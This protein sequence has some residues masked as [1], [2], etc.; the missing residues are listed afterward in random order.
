LP[1]GLVPRHA[2]AGW[3]LAT[4]LA[5]VVALVGTPSSAADP[6]TWPVIQLYVWLALTFIVA[7]HHDRATVVWVYATTVAALLLGLPDSRALMLAATALVLIGDLVRSRRLASEEAHRQAGLGE[8]ERSRRTVLEERTRIARDLHDVVAHH[9][10]MVVVQ[11][12][13]RPVPPERPARPGQER[14]RVDQRSARERSRRCAVCSG[15]CATRTS[16]SRSHRSRAWTGCR[17]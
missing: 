14:V 11:A 13:K 8:L 4:V 5:I 10:S 6:G 2:L 7:V 16:L 15:S 9:M 3:R 1:V 17:S 12:E